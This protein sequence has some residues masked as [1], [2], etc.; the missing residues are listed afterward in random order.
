MNE[1]LW[2]IPF[3]LVQLRRCVF[4]DL[5]LLHSS[6]LFTSTGAPP[7]PLCSSDTHK[8]PPSS[9]S[10]AKITVNATAGVVEGVA[11]AP[12]LK[13]AIEGC[14]GAIVGKVESVTPVESESGK[15][16]GFAVTLEIGE[17]AMVTAVTTDKDVEVGIKV[18][19]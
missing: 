15:K 4:L 9:K 18:R 7:L 17:P 2:F 10:T 3:L 14:A 19:V 13:D 16:K 11:H 1:W 5:V 6:T 8:M 12:K